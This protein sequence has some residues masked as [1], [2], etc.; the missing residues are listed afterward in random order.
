MAPADGRPPWYA[1][2]IR[3]RQ[4]FPSSS[5]LVSRVVFL[6]KP[7]GFSSFLFFSSSLSFRSLSIAESFTADCSQATIKTE[8]L[9][10]ATM[11]L[12]SALV[13]ALSLNLVNSAPAPRTDNGQ[14]FS[15]YVSL[16]GSIGHFIHS[17]V[18]QIRDKLFDYGNYGDY[19]GYGTYGSYGGDVETVTTTVSADSTDSTSPVDWATAVV[20]VTTTT[21]TGMPVATGNYEVDVT[22][23]SALTTGV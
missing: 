21:V 19:G 13:L 10:V 17:R 11:H 15:P 22:T 7:D 18:L 20:I 16:G 1:I 5:P 6:L 4:L 12:Q 3:E 2:C 23:I 8:Y 14:A 9:S